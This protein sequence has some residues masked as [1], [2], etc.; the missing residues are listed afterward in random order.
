MA[1]GVRMG[2]AGLEPVTPAVESGQSQRL[3]AP[4]F[5]VLDELGDGRSHE[6]PPALLG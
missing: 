5:S 3:V 1:P 6:E 4:A 2:G